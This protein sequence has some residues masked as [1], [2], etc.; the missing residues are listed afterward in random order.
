M[1]TKEGTLKWFNEVTG[2]GLILPDDGGRD[3]LVCG[4]DLAIGGSE[5]IEEGAAVSY[6]VNSRSGLRAFNVSLRGR[7]SW[8]DKSLKRHEGMEARNAYYAGLEGQAPL[9]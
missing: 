4:R 3:L 2:Y 6:E 5:P 9:G 7:H 8:Q 1:A